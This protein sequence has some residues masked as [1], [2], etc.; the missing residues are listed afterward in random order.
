MKNTTENAA[1]FEGL[2]T[3]FQ[4]GPDEEKDVVT[5]ETLLMKLALAETV[6]QAMSQYIEASEKGYGTVPEGVVS[7]SE[8]AISGLFQNLTEVSH[9]LE[10]GCYGYQRASMR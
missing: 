5:T 1:A 4:V 6:I 7:P 2:I 8:W 10:C 9:T 3:S